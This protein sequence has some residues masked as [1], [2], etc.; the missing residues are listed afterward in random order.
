MKLCKKADN[1]VAMRKEK[2]RQEL[3]GRH[4][5]ALKTEETARLKNLN[6]A[7]WDVL[8]NTS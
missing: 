2:L 3:M 5:I 7:S 8:G 6:A 4:K 1:G